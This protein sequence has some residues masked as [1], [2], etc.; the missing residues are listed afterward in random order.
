MVSKTAQQSRPQMLEPP[1]GARYPRP[2]TMLSKLQTAFGNSN[3]MLLFDPASVRSDDACC[4]GCAS[5]GCCEVQRSSLDGAPA[6]TGDVTAAARDSGQPLDTAIQARMSAHFGHDFSDVRVH[7]GES[8]A[9][10]ADALHAQA[11][12]VG[13][14]IVFGG[15]A[16]AP[17]SNA[18]LRVLAHE[19]AHVVQQRGTAGHVASDARVSEPDDPSERDAERAADDVMA[20]RSA[21]VSAPA[22][23]P[24][25]A[26]FVT[27][28]QPAAGCGVC[29]GPQAAGQ[30]AHELVQM[31]FQAALPVGLEELHFAGPG[32]NGFLDLAIA[33][34]TGLQIGEIKPANGNGY[35][36][37]ASDM[38]FY[39]SAVAAA[40]PGTTVTPMT[41]IFAPWVSIFPNPVAG[42]GCP[43]Q[44]LFVNPPLNGVYG[45]WCDPTFKDLVKNPNCK[46]KKDEE[47]KKVPVPVVGPSKEKKDQPSSIQR[48]TEFV[49]GV[50]AAGAF[51]VEAAAR[52]FLQENPDLVDFLIG[53]AI[54]L[55]V[56]MIAQDIVTAGAGIADN[57]LIIAIVGTL[58]RVAQQF[59][60]A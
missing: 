54:F 17:S 13:S 5:G 39:L 20:G 14:D 21:N 43:A 16:Y 34:P 1:K 57:P 22:G 23:E 49:E 4:A 6:A 8:A 42:G 3:V 51:D 50:I 35:A 2:E 15:G 40:F 29:Q 19:L 11:F 37:G 26:R 31:D 12:T 41:K 55:I 9:V 56:A 48:V 58:M 59:K 30:A 45:Y 25:V 10:A 28:E 38:I 47:P 32:G 24:A 60:P 27:V 7:V 18:G 33:T 46:C 36:E 44:N 52:Q 53:G